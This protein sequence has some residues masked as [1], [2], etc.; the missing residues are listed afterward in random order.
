MRLSEQDQYNS[1]GRKHKNQSIKAPEKS[2]KANEKPVNATDQPVKIT[3]QPTKEYADKSV[4]A[5]LGVL[6]K[7]TGEFGTFLSVRSSKYSRL[8]LS[9][10]KS[11]CMF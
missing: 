5:E 2:V 3:D 7:V 1:A 9:H 8:G 10:D 11:K 4:S 6:E